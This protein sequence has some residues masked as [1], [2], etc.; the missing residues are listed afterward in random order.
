M[1][2]LTREKSMLFSGISEQKRK[3]LQRCI[4]EMQKAEISGKPDAVSAAKA[5]LK[6]A[7]SLAS[8]AKTNALET[9]VPEGFTVYSGGRKSVEFDKAVD[10]PAC[11][12]ILVSVDYDGRGDDAWIQFGVGTD[13]AFSY[14]DKLP[15]PQTGGK[16]WLSFDLFAPAP[17]GA[18]RMVCAF[19]C[20]DE[21]IEV[22]V[23]PEYLFRE[24]AEQD[25][26]VVYSEVP[27]QELSNTKFYKIIELSGNRA[28]AVTPKIREVDLRWN[29]SL[30]H[31]DKDQRVTLQKNEHDYTQEWQIYKT[32]YG[33]YHLVN[34][35]NANHIQLD[36]NGKFVPKDVDMNCDGQDFDIS[37]A[38]P[39]KF[40]FT[41][42]GKPLACDNCK[43]GT[44]AV[45]E[46]TYADWVQTFSDEFDGDKLNRG[47]WD[48]IQAK[49]RPD[50][51]PVY[52]L[53]RPENHYMENGN[54]VIRT[55]ND[56]YEG[57]PQT[58]AYMDSRGL[59][60]V[61]YCKMEMSAR[62][63]TG[64]WIWPAF[65]SM[66]IVGNWPYQ[67]EIDVME[68]VGGGENGV[69]NSKLYGTLHW[70]IEQKSHH[71]EKGVAFY[72]KNYENLYDRYHTYAAEWEYDQIRLY[73]DDMLYMAMNLNADGMKWGFGDNPHYLI[74]NTSVRGSGQEQAYP[75]TAPESLYYI[76]WVRCYK[77][78]GEVTPCDDLAN[79]EEGYP[80]YTNGVAGEW[81]NKVCASS[82]GRYAAAAGQGGQVFVYDQKEDRLLYT[83]DNDCVAIEAISF[84]PDGKKLIVPDRDSKILVYDCGDFGAEPVTIMNEGTFG[85]FV[86][87]APA[88]DLIFTGGRDTIERGRQDR[89]D[90][91]YLRCWKSDGTFVNE[92]FAGSDVRNAAVSKDEKYAACV[93]SDGSMKLISL[94][95]FRL[96]KEYRNTTG[97]AMRGVDFSADG[98]HLA[99]SD[100]AGEVYLCTLK[101]LEIKTMAKVNPSSVK[102]VRFSEDGTQVL[103]LCADSC[104]RLFDVKTGLLSALLGGFTEMVSEAKF[105][106]DGKYIAV[107]SYD[108]R[109]KLF[110]ANGAYIS[111]YKTENPKGRWVMDF[112]F[113]ADS[114]RLFAAMGIKNTDYC[115]WNI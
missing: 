79:G 97:A 35:S 65:W 47:N 26:R 45:Y 103:A 34:K 7:V 38:G 57:I 62:I 20:E 40:T 56:G 51:E 33:K 23:K 19:E 29:E 110:D 69:E 31:T 108:G 82:D 59:Y 44:W 24:E 87:Y 85:E 84:T 83:L 89:K 100:E 18:E 93:C 22:S 42:C 8:P 72:A 101:N 96:A 78:A 107:S 86:A 80:A 52:F 105:S 113:S 66:G 99:F 12:G 28:L 37:P 41:C 77:R 104:A 73:I 27:A 74:L 48:V 25:K 30:I 53:D 114:K 64:N 15:L 63:S 61:S 4:T 60:G 112:A 102:R 43:S 49:I 13:E 75:E 115:V 92:F 67:G 16:M 11:D 76:D 81:L 32:E 109:I 36:E 94:P 91:R 3:Y 71:M 106:P 54:L 46:C 111:T 21:D 95:D 88:S 90:S 6:N 39:G 9:K 68:A 10:T 55:S 58:G 17:N 14:T 70:S 1:D 2:R 98:R 5:A 50:G